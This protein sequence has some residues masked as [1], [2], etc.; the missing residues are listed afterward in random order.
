[1]KNNCA[2]QENN[3]SVGY[4]CDTIKALKQLINGLSGLCDLFFHLQIF[5]TQYKTG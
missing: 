4:M 5:N 2:T 1:M 3:H